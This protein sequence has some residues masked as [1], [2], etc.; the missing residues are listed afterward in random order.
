[1]HSHLHFRQKFVLVVRVWK[2]AHILPVFSHLLF[3][4]ARSGETRDALPLLEQHLTIW[5]QLVQCLGNIS[6]TQGPYLASV[7][8]W[9][10]QFC[11]SGTT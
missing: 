1:M 2:E 10:S 5:R 4:T 9:L 7:L 6:S 11:S 3:L 8:I